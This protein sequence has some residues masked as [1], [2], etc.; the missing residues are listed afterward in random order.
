MSKKRFKIANLI[1]DDWGISLKLKDYSRL[2]GT[3]DY[4]TSTIKINKNLTHDEFF[5]T[6]FHEMAHIIL[7]DEYPAYF[8]VNKITNKKQL[9]GVMLEALDAELEADDFGEELHKIYMPMYFKN[10]KNK[11]Y[12]RTYERTKEGLKWFDQEVMEYY[13]KMYKA[14]SK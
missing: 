11:P 7:H 6:L 13:R 10:K 12:K 8:G 1:C 3:A 5:C 4:K 9:K 14:L 2:D